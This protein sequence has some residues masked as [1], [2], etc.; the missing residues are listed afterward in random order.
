MAQRKLPAIPQ[1]GVCRLLPYAADCG[2][3]DS[4]DTFLKDTDLTA[5]AVSGSQFSQPSGRFVHVFKGQFESA[6]MHRNKEFCPQIAERFQGLVRPHVDAAEGV[7]VVSADGEEGNFRGTSA[8]DFLET[9]EI[10]AVA[11][12]IN[13]AALVFDQEAAVAP[14]IVAQH[15]R[16]PVLG[17]RQCHPPIA[18]GEALPPLQF[19]DALEAEVGGEVAHAP[20]HDADFRRGQPAESGAMKMIEVGVS[21]QDQINGG[22]VLDFETGAADAFEQEE[23]VGEIGINQDVQIGELGQE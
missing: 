19:D 13:A 14:V 23:P 5:E 6:V 2:S 4:G 11:G 15:A 22:E 20:G 12:V 9:R 7:G 1:S 8:P 16:A 21:Q 3:E 17:R 10:G 18:V